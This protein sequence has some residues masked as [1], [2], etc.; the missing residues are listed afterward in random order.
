MKWVEALKKYAEKAGKYVVPKKGT[1]E[2]DEVR[3]IM[4]AGKPAPAAPAKPAPAASDAPAPA[5]APK[6]RGRKPKAKAEA[7]AVAAAPAA[8]APKVRKPRAPRKPRAKEGGELASPAMAMAMKADNKKQAPEASSAVEAKP[9]IGRAKAKAGSV[10]AGLLPQ[11]ATMKAVKHSKNPEAVLESATNAHLPVVPAEAMVGLRVQ[12]SVRQRL[13][14]EAVG[15]PQ[16]PALVDK[17]KP[18]NAAPFSFQK[19]RNELGC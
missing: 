4:D 7:P 5:A 9:R 15:E 11:G 17:D 18:V 3:R 16:L 1:A 10:P 8:K 2:Y 6:K 19:L 12:K 14:A 13:A